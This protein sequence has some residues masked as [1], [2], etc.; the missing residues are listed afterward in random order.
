MNLGLLFFFKYYNFF[1]ENTIELLNHFHLRS[2]LQL[3]NI[4]QPIGISFFTFQTIGYNI[5]VYKGKIKPT[6]NL[7]VF[8]NFTSFFPQVFA[9]P[10]ER[11]SKFI[12]QLLQKRVFDYQQ[13]TDGLR[14][15]AY[16]LFKK[17]VIADLLSY[18]VGN[19]FLNYESFSSTELFLGA[20]YFYIQ[21]YCDFSGYSDIAIGTAKLFG[22]TLST[23]FKT[24]FFGKTSQE[25]WSR[26]NI[27]L[28]TWFR[29]YV[30][31][32]LLFRHKNSM[33]WRI[34]CTI[35]LFVLIGF[36]HG[37]NFTFLVFGL[38]NGIYFIPHII[39]KKSIV[40]RSALD[41]LKHNNFFSVVSV[42]FLFVLG[43][44][45]TVFFR[46]ANVKL[47]LGYLDRLFQLHFTI[48]S[49]Y[50]IKLLPLIILFL[51]WEWVQRNKDYQFAIS[52]YAPILKPAL[53]YIL[54]FGILIFGKF[55]DTTFIYFRF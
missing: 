39:S 15:I 29:D 54:L 26:W 11:G 36:W 25:V 43:S 45:T 22:I 19:I 12:P 46:S 21:I 50:Y 8:L 5:D 13:A 42:A 9:G 28:T 32:P 30:Y 40:L 10:I 23:N 34:F 4:V 55:V 33:L 41:Y 53:Y 24:P 27:T 3:L 17:M 52:K 37:A 48:P 16:G 38:L 18:R 51:T 35:F 1:I 6:K 2:N 7:I 44:V 31:M 20:A 14:Q 49:P 47:A